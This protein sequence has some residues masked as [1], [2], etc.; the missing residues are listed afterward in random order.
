MT[1]T[2]S[3]LQHSKFNMWLCGIDVCL[4]STFDPVIDFSNF[5]CC[6]QGQLFPHLESEIAGT[7]SNG[8]IYKYRRNNDYD[9]E[10]EN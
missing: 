5:L 7:K 3:S 1:W 10:K 8:S 6:C 9:N 2:L 4:D